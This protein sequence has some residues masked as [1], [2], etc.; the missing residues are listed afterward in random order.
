MALRM[1]RQYLL[2]VQELSQTKGSSPEDEKCRKNA[3]I[4]K[5]YVFRHELWKVLLSG[6]HMFGWHKHSV[7]FLDELILTT[8]LVCSMLEEYAKGK[9]LHVRSQ[10]GGKEEERVFAERQFNFVAE[11]SCLVDYEVVMAYIWAC[12]HTERAEIVE[13]TAA[14]F[15]RMIF[16]FKQ[17]WVFYT[18]EVLLKLEK[19][20]SKNSNTLLPSGMHNLL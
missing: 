7:E 11:L 2:V 3:S 9:V 20:L 10:R 18:V 14:F 8:H 1:L 19:A 6:F 4:L 15:K 13:C 16:Q 5:A 12:E 17:P